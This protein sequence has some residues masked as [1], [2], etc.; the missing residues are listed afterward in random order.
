VVTPRRVWIGSGI[1][2]L[3]IAATVAILILTL[4]HEQTAARP[5]QA[6]SGE[7]ALSKSAALFADPVQA[8]IEVLVDRDRVDPARVGFNPTWVLYQLIGIPKLE[9]HDTGRTTQL[10]Y[11]ANLVCLTYSCLPSFTGTRVQFPPAKVFFTLRNGGGRRTLELP[12]SAF[13]LGPRTQL[14]DLNNADPFV[15]PAW[16]ATTEPEAVSYAISPTTLR[17]SLFAG[18]AVLFLLALGTFFLFARALKRRWRPKPKSP[19]EQA[20]VLVEKASARE[21]QQAKRKALEL[22]SREL[23]HTGEGELA[24]TARELAWAEATPVPSSTQPL[25]LDVRRLIAERSNGHAR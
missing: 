7:T 21:D 23:A 18:A 4:D 20:V 2:V 9:R 19:L 5:R 8:R 22:L 25:T 10:V 14:S 3:A 17:S 11:T 1:V 16:R 15:Q 6:I 13:A 24:L 12:W